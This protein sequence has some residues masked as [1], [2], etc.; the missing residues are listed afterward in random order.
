MNIQPKSIGL[1]EKFVRV[2]HI[3]EEPDELLGQ[4]NIYLFI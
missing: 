2:F 1:A 3:T 4:P